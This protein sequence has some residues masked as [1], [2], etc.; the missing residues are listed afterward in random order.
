MDSAGIRWILVEL[1]TPN[2]DVALK[3][4]NQLDRF[5]RKGLSQIREWREWIQDNLDQARRPRAQNGLGLP[6]IR[7]QA[8]GLLLVGRRHRLGVRAATLQ[9]QT[10]EQEGIA[11][12]TYDWL[13]EQLRGAIGFHGPPGA[14]PYLL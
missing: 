4:S 3:S 9:R 6:D 10:E 11:V 7:P 5:A 14:N 2:S 12:H 13:L 8:A 1:E